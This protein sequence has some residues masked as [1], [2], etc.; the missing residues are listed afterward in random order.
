VIEQ[1]TDEYDK[2]LIARRP[3]RRPPLPP[4]SKL[5]IERPSKEYPEWL[6]QKRPGQPPITPVATPT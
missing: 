6:Q 5:E 1:A 2:W 4:E 3:K